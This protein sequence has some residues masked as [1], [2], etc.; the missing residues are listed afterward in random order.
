MSDAT[1]NNKRLEGDKEMSNFRLVMALVSVSFFVG[2]TAVAKEKKDSNFSE[3]GVNVAFSPF[4]GAINF[5]YNSSTKT[6]WQFGF[7]GAP[8]LFEMEADIEDVTYKLKGSSAW[9]GMFLNH[10]PI[11]KAQWFR[12]VA[13]LG[14]GKIENNIKDDKGN[15]YR[16]SYTENPVAYCGIGFGVDTT[17]GF[18][19]GFDLGMLYTGGA[20]VDVVKGDGAAAED[21][22]DY[23]MF[24][25]VLPNAQIT[26]GYN[27]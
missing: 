11:E 3:Y 9:T 6:S 19:V 4:G 24:G 7:G 18:K 17:K 14:F 8:E 25:S 23:W 10:R 12:L 15:H 27:F 21:I 16:V 1:S 22:R 13:G 5:N 26:L 2:Q 20:S